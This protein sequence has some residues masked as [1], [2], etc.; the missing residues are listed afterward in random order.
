MTFLPSLG[1]KLLPGPIGLMTFLLASVFG[2][3]QPATATETQQ[4]EFFER[5]IR[6][7][8]VTHCLECHGEGGEVAGGLSLLSARDWA[9]G[10]DSGPAIQR[11]D[12]DASV[13]IAALQYQGLEMPPEGQLPQHTID[14]FKRWIADGAYDPREAPPPTSGASKS[15]SM[16]KAL[17]LESA[18]EFWAFRPPKITPPAEHPSNDWAAGWIDR[19]I[20]AAHHSAGIVPAGDASPLTLLRRLFYD[21][22]GLP[23]SPAL[24]Q[25]FLADPGEIHY[26]KIVDRLLHSVAY[27]EH[28]GRHWLD[29]ARY[30][31]SNGSDFNATFHHAWR[32]RD[33]VIDSIG[34]DKP[35]RQFV[36]EQI[37][38]D[39]MP[40]ESDA[41]RAEQLIAT[42]F[43]MIG[44]KMLSERDKA[45]LEMD[46]VDEQIDTVG[47]AFMG[48]TLGCARC[49]DHKFDPVPTA[50]YYSL[51]GIFRSTKTLEGESQRYVS[52]WKNVP[53]PTTA[54]HREAVE[55]F[56]ADEKHALQAVKDAKD[57]LD[58]RKI[59]LT[60]T[61]SN[62][63]VIDA[64]Q[65]KQK[66]M[67]VTSSYSPPIVG[68]D[69]LHDNDAN[70][71]SAK[72][73]FTIDVQPGEHE[74]HFAYTAGS[75]RAANVPV[76]IQHTGGIE[77][78]LLDQRQKPPIDGRWVSLGSFS[79]QQTAVVTVTN[80]NT[81]GHVI[82]DGL[83]FLPTDPATETANEDAA[84]RRTALE[85]A[86]E[87]AKQDLHAC[88]RELAALRS[89]RPEPLP[90]AMAVRDQPGEDAF[91]CI[92]GEVDN[93]GPRVSRGFL[94][95][96]SPQQQW[97]LPTD[98]SGRLQLA[99]W[100]VDPRHPLTARV[101]VNRVWMHLFGEGLVATVDNFGTLG[102]RP[103]HPELLDQLALQFIEDG[104]SLRRL[105]RRIV[106][107][108]SYRQASD[109][110]AESA[111]IDPE[112]RLL[113]RA[114]R[115]RQVIESM[116]DTLLLATDRLDRTRTRNPMGSF[117]TLVNQNN[118]PADSV[119]V[120]TSHRRTVYTSIIRGNVPDLLTT[121]DFAD[122]D[123][124][125]GKRPQTNVPAQALM[126]LN[127]PQIIAWCQEIAERVMGDRPDDKDLPDD[128]FDKRLRKLY[129]WCLQRYPDDQEQQLAREFTDTI[130][131][132]LQAWTLLAQTL[133]AS[134]EFRFRD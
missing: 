108:R 133:V 67:W 92:R 69:Y 83:R 30:A 1:T 119:A 59:Q 28:W 77:K 63:I 8:L 105:I 9:A 122:P 127:D 6:P 21:L 73:T 2:V 38:G 3:S 126:L 25:E 14:H 46:V 124:L 12:P 120:R 55:Q 26:Q 84:A 15:E 87:S 57:R 99:E 115:R 42:G 129:L 61:E 123:M 86:V 4:A 40:F 128:A 76:E 85:K 91:V 75:G 23:P 132:A 72:L 111:R 89:E 106:L 113:W 49:H 125:V 53:L 114:N 112:N 103:T 64:R 80:S 50:D 117:G 16:H 90:L 52:T 79:F 51:A 48:L 74:I 24:I 34:R 11:G 18:G 37:A 78:V 109:F 98:Q 20:A 36:L 68:K 100:L 134:T 5:H 7:I 94:R 13:L 19:Y 47:R 45:K 60:Q 44:P 82:V 29:V 65:A 93:L 66:G 116:R 54:A 33:Y 17:D 130:D 101:F 107:S 22:T 121:F 81:K 31:D 71:G 39:L 32:Y 95:A 110:V 56:E 104:W 88:E 35:F 96:C 131:D 10:G 118:A 97:Y 102:Q 43:L 41:Q 70:K 27:A 58:N 62:A